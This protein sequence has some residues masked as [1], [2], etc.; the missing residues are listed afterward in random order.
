MSPPKKKVKHEDASAH[1]L[2]ALTDS[3][4]GCISAA[5]MPDVQSRRLDNQGYIIE[6]LKKRCEYT[7][8]DLPVPCD[9]RWSRAFISTAILWYSVQKNIWNVPKEELASAL[10]R[11]FNVVY[12]SIKYRVTPAGSVFAVVSRSHVVHALL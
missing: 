9:Q 7:N 8:R 12:P 10:Q 1:P 4:V 6:A 2:S 3:T 11:I 5:G